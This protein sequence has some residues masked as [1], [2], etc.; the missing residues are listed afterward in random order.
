[1]LS[2]RR[3]PALSRTLRDLVRTKPTVI[4][5][6]LIRFEMFQP[7]GFSHEATWSSAVV[8]GR[9]RRRPVRGPGQRR[10]VP[11]VPRCPRARP[12]RRQGRP[13]PPH[14]LR[15]VPP[16][17]P[18]HPTRAQ[19]RRLRRHHHVL[20]RHLHRDRQGRDAGPDHLGANAGR[21]AT[22]RWRG[23]ESI[24]TDAPDPTSLGIVQLLADDITWDGFTI[25]G[26]NRA[27]NSPGMYTSPT[28][29]GYLSATRSS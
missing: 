14:L 11:P 24:V 26:V 20:P 3:R 27:E 21:D 6:S 16:G 28:S 8:R 5:A 17:V 1:M 13:P 4:V 9:R 22:G 29:S 10:R 25:Q 2:V 23:P 12:G 7:G 15:Q 18:G 19:R